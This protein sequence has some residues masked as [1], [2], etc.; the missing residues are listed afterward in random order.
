M[1]YLE[2]DLSNQPYTATDSKPAG[3]ADLDFRY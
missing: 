2:K 1:A 3:K